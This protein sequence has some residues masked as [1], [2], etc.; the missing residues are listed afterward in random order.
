MNPLM[1]DLTKALNV[2]IVHVTYMTTAS[3]LLFPFTPHRKNFKYF[4]EII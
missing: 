1:D 4:F 3:V 2:N